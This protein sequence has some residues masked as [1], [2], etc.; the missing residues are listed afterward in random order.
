MRLPSRCCSSIWSTLAKE[1]FKFLCLTYPSSVCC[2]PKFFLI[3][4]FSLDNRLSNNYL[5]YMRILEAR[6][7]TVH[8][9]NDSAD[10]QAR[11]SIP[12]S[13]TIKP[14]DSSVKTLTS[15][16]S[17]DAGVLY[18][19]VRSLL[20]KSSSLLHYI[21]L[22]KPL[23]IALTETWLDYTMPSSLFCPDEFTAYRKDR[24]GKRGGGA[25]LLVKNNVVSSP[26][27]LHSDL[28]NSKNS[29]VDV[30]ACGIT[31]YDNSKLGVLCIYRPPYS[32]VNDDLFMMDLIQKFLEF[33][34]DYN[35]IMGDFN[36]PDI[37]WP[38]SASSHQSKAFLTFC[39]E[40]FLT[41]HV[42]SPTRPLSNTIL[43][44]I[45]ST[46]GT[47]ISNAS[48][49]EEFDS[50]DHSILQFSI[51]IKTPHYTKKICTRDLRNV[52]WAHFN[53][54][55]SISEDWFDALATKDIDVVW[56]SFLGAVTPALDS[57]A[58]LKVKS[59]RNFISSSSIRTAL[60]HKRRSFH[61]LRQHPCVRNLLSYE[62]AKLILQNSVDCDI[63]SREQ[64]VINSKDRHLF[65]SYVN[66]RLSKN[67]FLSSINHNG[68][69]ISDPYEVANVFN[70]YFVSTF[71]AADSLGTSLPS[72]VGNYSPPTLSN[73]RVQVEDVIQILRKIPSKTSVDANNL[74]YKILKNGGPNLV[75]RLSHLFSLSLELSRI[76]SSW[77]SAIVRPIFKKG[78]KLEVS[79]YR[80]ISVTS[81]CSRVLER[82]INNKLMI[83]LTI[84]NSLSCSQHGFLKGKSTETALIKFYDFVTESV[85]KNLIV[86]TIFFDF[87]KAFDSVS[88]CRLL[89]RLSSIGISESL[90]CWIKDFL[91]DR[92]QKVCVNH[93][94]SRSLPVRSGVIQGSVLGPTLFNIFINN[95]DN[96][97]QHC[98][99]LKYA[100][101]IRIFLAADK[102]SHSLLDMQKQVQDDINN[103]V[104][105]AHQSDLKL[106]VVKCFS[107]SFG[108][109]NS[110]RSYNISNCDIPCKTEFSDLGLQVHSS[111][112]F[113]HHVENVVSKG[114]I[115]LGLINKV[116]KNK[117]GKSTVQLYNAF[118]RPTVDYL[119]LIW[120]PYTKSA[121]DNIERVQRRMCNLV[122]EVRHL[123]YKEQLSSLGIY[124]LQARRLR[125][126]IISIFKIYKGFTKLNFNEFFDLCPTHRTRGHNSR[127][128]P[129]FASRNYR[130]HFFTVSAIP[131]WN[132]LT[133]ED[134]DVSSV[135]SFKARLTL[136]FNK[137]NI[138]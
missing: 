64:R 108:H 112:Q 33:K 122:P 51:K 5:S 37:A 127:I 99:I 4:V 15:E 31:T 62:R 94:F 54:L 126:Q 30:I 27:I 84:S 2:L 70:N 86:D 11:R 77:K 55:L 20:P 93:C 29:A 21:S 113:K 101:D 107:V 80:P 82:I 104:H 43:D 137:N 117:S 46:H 85:D 47:V 14:A 12:P 52:D 39:N 36:F 59:A 135:A 110:T 56:S 123:P 134:I 129:K 124:S 3:C 90:V 66:R 67:S 63:A 96:V 81:C 73:I 53:D 83:L 71:P 8:Y 19:N 57:V 88:H 13:E 58:P 87:Q 50:S 121:I 25:L 6:A 106:S 89:S 102:S 114:L 28:P 9:S 23:I 92:T 22:Y 34:F 75:L 97:V 128:I 105:W 35:V 49:N 42:T 16:P 26:I 32:S 131:Y 138:W 78:S 24:S 125:Y 1:Y 91:S 68:D 111:L 103:L 133:Q 74:S 76:P 69:S 136:F 132:Q 79:N 72:G 38:Y 45:L 130:L 120:S 95:I 17:S 10:G 115:K 7:G 48:V 116:F 98:N 118:V 44:L 100:D 18:S 60:R 119:S 40:N 109:H 61:N 65:W 41:Q